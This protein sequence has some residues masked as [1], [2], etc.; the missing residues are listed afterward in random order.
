MT[1]ASLMAWAERLRKGAE[2]IS[3]LMFAGIFFVF[4]YGIVMRYAF[5]K[6]L[7]WGDEVAMLLMLWCTFWTDALVVRSADHIAFDILWDAVS[8]RTRRIIGIVGSALFAL[9][10]IAAFPIVV[11]YI[12]FLKR[13]RTDALELRLDLVFSCFIIYMVMVILRLIVRFIVM[14]GPN[15][16]DHVASADGPSTS[17]VVG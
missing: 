1:S 14:C 8:P 6:P 17:N 13:E 4:I 11:D 5:H 12:L 16:R 15:W 3:A 9:I 2:F 7:L 10:F